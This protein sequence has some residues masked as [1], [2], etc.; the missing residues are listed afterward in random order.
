MRRQ[1]SQCPE[2]HAAAHM[3]AASSPFAPPE[4]V[5]RGPSSLVAGQRHPASTPGGRTPPPGHRGTPG[6][7]AARPG[8]M[9]FVGF[10]PGAQ[11]GDDG[12]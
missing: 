11:G 12:A 10:A 3:A 6:R 7:S 2:H 4:D 9:Y 1:A 8:R 5:H